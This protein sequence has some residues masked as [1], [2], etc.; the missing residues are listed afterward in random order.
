MIDARQARE[1]TKARITQLAQE[2]IINYVSEAVR[3]SINDGFFF[4]SIPT[5]GHENP[6]AIGQEIVRLLETS[7]GYKAA[8]TYREDGPRIE[9]YVT[10]S[11]EEEEDE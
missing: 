9:Q 1:E 10:V 11:W 2:F 3:E 4:T 7:Y 8:F 6:E 5:D